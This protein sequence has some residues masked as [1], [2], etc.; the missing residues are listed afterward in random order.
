MCV[1]RSG[2]GNWCRQ[3]PKW[4]FSCLSEDKRGKNIYK[5][6]SIITRDRKEGG[7]QK[8]RGKQTAGEHGGAGA[9]EVTEMRISEGGGEEY[10]EF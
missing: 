3:D 10:F 1:C 5:H 4:L 9:V 2:S 6:D 8:R 7:L